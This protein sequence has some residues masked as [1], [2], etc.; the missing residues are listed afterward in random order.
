M[1]TTFRHK[2]IVLFAVALAFQTLTAGAQTLVSGYFLEGNLQRSMLNPAFAGDHNYIAVPLI[3]NLSVGTNANVGLSDFLYPYQRDGYAL[4]TF[5]SGTVD[6]DE[7][8]ARIPDVTRLSARVDA[9]LLAAGFRS[10]GGYSTLRISLRSEAD[11]AVPKDFFAFAKQGLQNS[12]YTLSGLRVNALAYG[13]VAFGHSHS[14]GDN[15]SVGATAHALV[16]GA[17]ADVALRKLQ[18]K[19][20]ETAW[21]AQ[22]E[23]AGQV[24]TFGKASCKVEADGTSSLKVSPGL[25]SLGLATDLGAA[26]DLNEAVSGLRVSAALTDIGFM[27]WGSSL[28][29]RTKESTFEFSGFGEIDPQNLS[30]NEE[31]DQI[32]DDLTEMISIEFAEGTGFW[33]AL[34]PL[35]SVGAE[36]DMPFCQKVSTALLLR[37]RFGAVAGFTDARVYVNAAPWEWLDMSV[38][39][40]ASTFGAEMGWMVDIHPR[41]LSFF[42]GSDCM[43]FRVTPQ[44]IP[45]NHCNVNLCMGLNI[46]F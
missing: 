8:L 28:D 40:G 3:G 30:L 15:L 32:A 11:M 16:G 14:L 33:T 43:V 20:D 10:F 41:V 4:T 35:L 13:D 22:S 7:F 9:T 25:T 31:L 17:T 24:A 38:N 39:V 19:L 2:Y 46:P 5:M 37:K 1:K 12:H 34:S 44:Y 18:L 29:V 6:A 36:Y 45:V 27:R 21:L 26:Y 23:V 42:I